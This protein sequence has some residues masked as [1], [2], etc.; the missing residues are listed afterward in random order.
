MPRSKH[1][2][3]CPWRALSV[4]WDPNAGSGSKPNVLVAAVLRLKERSGCES[5]PN[6]IKWGSNLIISTLVWVD[7]AYYPHFLQ[8]HISLPVHTKKILS[9]SLKRHSAYPKLG[10]TRKAAWF[11]TTPLVKGGK[12]NPTTA[13]QN[14]TRAGEQLP[15]FHALKPPT[16]M[17]WPMVTIVQSTSGMQDARHLGSEN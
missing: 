2:K 12:T 13:K 10:T 6:N 4:T 16:N 9:K 1:L 7:D 15:L 17:R 5:K 14:K 3:Q 8:Q 11:E